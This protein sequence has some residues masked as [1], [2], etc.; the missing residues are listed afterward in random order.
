MISWRWWWNWN[1]DEVGYFY[2]EVVVVGV[3]KVWWFCEKNVYL[4]LFKL[5]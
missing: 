4:F 5:F 3:E 1:D 2:D